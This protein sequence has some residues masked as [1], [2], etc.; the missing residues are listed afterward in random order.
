MADPIAALRDILATNWSKAPKPSIEDIAD[1]DQ[2]DAKRVRLLDTDVIRI[3]ETAHNEAQPELLYDYVNE[4]VNI[5]IDCRTVDS[6]L[7][8]SAMRDEVRRILYAFRKGDGTNFDRIIY[9]TRTDLSD[10]SKKLFRYTLQCEIV[11]FSSLASSA[12]PVVNPATGEVV[13]STTYQTYD[14]DL[15]AIANLTPTDGHVIQGNGSTWVTA[16]LAGDITEVTAGTALSGGGTSGAVTLNVSGLTISEFAANS[17]QI[18]SESFADNDTSVMTSAAIADKIEAYGYTTQVGDITGVTAGTGMAGGGTSGSV[19]LNLDLKDEDN[20]ASNSASHAASQQSIKAYVDSEVT[21]LIDS[22]PGALDTLNELAAAINDDASFASTITTSIGTKLAKASNLSDLANAGTARSNLG[23]GSLATLSSI[24]IS[25]NTNL[26]VSAPITLTGDTIGLADPVALSQLNESNDATD[27]KILLWDESAS[28]WKYMTIDDLQ[29]SIDTSSGNTDTTY[30]ISTA[31]SG[32]D[33]NIVLTAGGSGSGTDTVKIAAGTNVQIAHTTDTITVSSTDTNTTYSAGTGLALSGTTFSMADPADGT[34]IDESTADSAD[35]MPIWDESASSWKYITIDNLQDEIDTGT[36][37]TTEQVQDIV[38]GMFSGNTETRIAATYED[39]DGTIDLVVDDMTANDNTFRTVTAGGNTLGGSET[40]AFTAGSNVTITENGGAVTIASTD[41]NTTYSVGDGGLTQNNFTNALKTK[42]DGIEASSDVTDKANVGSALASLTGD[43]TLYI[44]DTGDDTTVRVRGNFYVDGTTTT[45]NQTQVNVQ[46]AF[47]FEGATADNYET[48]LTITDPTADRTITLPDAAGTVAVAAGTG[49]ALSAAGSMSLSHLGIQS[50]SDPDAD[51]ILIWDDSAGAVAWAAA[52]TNLAIS[53]TNINATDTDTTY[54]AGTGLSLS[55]TTFAL[56]NG[57]I[58]EVHL[59]ATNSPTD[60]YLLSYDDA[61]GGFT[62]IAAG[63]GGEN[64]QNAFSIVA[65]SG[66]DNVAADATT[67]TLTLA[68]GSNVTITTTAGTDTVTIASADTNTQLSTEAVQDIVGAMFGSN[69]ETRIS[70]TYEDGDGTIDLVVDDMT[71][72]DNTWRTVTAGGNTLASNEALDFVAGSNVTITES[73]GDVTFASTDT[74]TTYSAGTGLTLSGTTFSMSDP[75]DGSS[76]DEGTI[77]TDDRMPIWDESASSWKYVTIDN[78]QDEI[79]TGTTLT[80]EE[81]Q[82]IVGGMFTGNTETSITATYQDGDGT[83]DLVVAPGSDQGVVVNTGGALTTLGYIHLALENSANGYPRGIAVGQTSGGN[84][85]PGWLTTTHDNNLLID[86]N[87]GTNSGKIEIFEGS[88]NNIAITPHG[89]GKIV[90][91]GLLWPNADGTAN[92]VLQTNGTGA[93]SWAAQTSDTWRTVTVAGNDSLTPSEA[94][95]FN[96]GSNV[97]ITEQ[98]GSVTIASTD[99]NTQL[100]LLDEDNMAT[101]SATAAASQ[102]S[103]KAYVDAE[104]SGLVDSSPAALNTLNELAAALGDDASFSTTVSTNIGL[105]LAK[106][107]NL[108]DLASASTARSNLGL[109][110]G[111]VLSTAAISDG[112]TGLATADQ[113]H[114]F[115]TGLGYITTDTNTWRTITAGGNTLSTSETLAFTAGSNVTITESGG[116]VTIASTDTNTNTQLSTEQVQDIVGAMFSSNTETRI[117]ATYEDGDGTIDLVVDDMT[118]NDNT[119]RTITAGGNTLAS[120]ETLAFTAGSNVTITESGGAVTIASTDTNTNTTY[121]AGTNISLSGTTFNVDDAFLKNDANDTTSGT[122]TAGGFTTT[123]TWTFDDASS[124]T[125]GITTV[126]TG[127]GFAD[128]DTSLMTAGAIKEKIEAYGFGVGGG[129]ITAVVAGTGLSGGA[130]SGSATVNLSHLGLEA[131]ADPDADSIFFW[132]DS[133]GAAKFL[134]TGSNLTISGTT[135]TATDTNTQLSTEQV[136]DIVGAMFSSNTET[137]IAATYE[138]GDGTIDLV[139][140]DMTADTNTWRTITAGGNTLS[141]SETLAFTA[142]SNVTISENGGAVTIA[143]T[144]TNTT[145]S[146]GDGGLTQNNFTNTLKSKLDAIEAS[147]D[148]TDKTN[149]SAA[150]ALLDDGDTLYIG[151]AGN[152]TTVRIRGNFYV[153]GTTTSVNQTEV[154]VQNAF[155]FEGATADGYETTLTITDPTA[156]RTITLPNSSGTIS[157]SDTQLS[158]EQVQDIVG[159]MFSSNTETRIAATYEDG[160][161]TIDLVVDD[162]TAN[163]N[164]WRTVTAGGNTLSTSETLAFTAGSNVTITESGGA[165]T[166]ASAD[167][168]TQLSTEA[169]QDIVGAMFSGNTETNTAVTYQD[170]DGTIDVVTTLDGAPL[171]TEA[172]QDIV[173]A[174]FSSNTETRIAA[175]YEDG[176]GTIDL[177]VDDMTT[178]TNTFRTV[179]AGGNT[180]STS[181]TLAFTAGTGITIAESGGAVTITNS[182]TD[183]DTWRGITAGGN[184]LASNETLAFTA[185]SNVTITESGGAVTIAS[186]DTNTTYAVMGGGNSYAAGLVVTGSAT[187]NSAFLRKDGEWVV[188]T[189]TDTNTQLSTEQVQDIVGAMFSSNTETRIAA[190]YEDGDGTIDLVVDDMTANT[191]TQNEYA[192]SWVDSSADALLRLT[193]SGAGSG[194]QDIKIVAGSNIT[195]TPSGT[196]LTIAA[197]DTNTTYSVGDGGLTQNNFTNTLKS[198]LDGIEASADVTDKANVSSALALLSG[199]DTLYIGDS[200]DDTTVRVRGNFYVDGTTTTVNQTEVNVQNA[201]VFEGATA[202][203][204]ETTLT[205]TDPTADRTITLPDAAGTVTVAAG[206]GLAL[207]AAGSMSLSHLGIQSLSDPDADRILIWDESAGAVAWATANS[208]LA[209]SGTNINATDTDTNTTYSAGTGLALST[210]TFSVSGA[211]TGITTDYNTARK[212]GRDTDNLIDFTT[213]NQVTF[214]VSANDGVVFKAS[215]EIEATS[216]DISGDVD[217]DGTLEADAITINGSA[218]GSIYSPVAGHASIVTVGTIGTGTWQGTAIAGGY[219]ANDAIDSQHYADGSI[220]NAHIADDAIDSEHYADGSI[221]NVHIA[222]HSLLEP[223]LKA[224]NTPTDN[225]LLSYDSTTTGFTWVEASSGITASSTDTL[226]NKTYGPLSSGY[227]VVGASNDTAAITSNGAHNLHLSTNSNSNSGSIYIAQGANNDIVLT[228]NGTGD[229]VLDGLKWPQADG[230]ANYV[231]K[232]DGSAQLSWV[233]QTADTNTTYSGG[234]GL[235]LSSTTFNVDAAQTQITSIGT[236]GTGVWQGTAIAQ[237]YIAD[238]AINEAK[239]QVSNGPTNGYVLTAQSGNTGG[240]TWAAAASGGASDIDGLS[241]AKKAGTNFTDSLIIGHQTTGTLSSASDNTAVGIGAMDAITSGWS[242]TIVGKDAGTS[243]TSAHNATFFGKDAGKN[244]TTSAYTTMIGAGGGSVNTVTGNYNTSLGYNALRKLS[245][246]HYNLALGHQAL[247]EVNSASYNLGIGYNAGAEI[248]TGT[249]NLAIGHNALDLA[250][251]ESDNI[252]IGYDA[253]GGSVAGGE[254]N[255]VIGNYAGDALTSADNSV[256]IGHNAGSAVTTGAENVMVG[257]QAGMGITD[258]ESNIFIGQSTGYSG[259]SDETGNVGI[260]HLA[261]SSIANAD[262]NVGVGYK[263]GR[264]VK[265]QHNVYLGFESGVD[266]SNTGNKN[267]GIGYQAANNITTGSNN[268]VIG[269]ADVTADASDQLSISSGDGSPVWITGTS[270]GSVNL[271]NS[272]LKI[273]GSVGSDGQVLTSTGSAVAWEDAGGGGASALNGLTDVISNI[274]NFTDSILISPDGAAPPHG[275]LSSATDNVGIGKDAFA[276]L[277]SG[278]YNIAIGSNSLNDLTTGGSNV[279][280]GGWGALEKVTTQSGNVAIGSS[281]GRYITN[282]GNNTFVGTNAGTGNSGG[283]AASSNVGIGQDVMY[284]INGVANN[285]VGIGKYALRD[286][287]TTGDD[288]I[289]IGESAGRNISTA[290]ELIVIGTEAGYT[291]STQSDNIAIGPYAMKLATGGWN[292]AIGN[293]ALEDATGNT[294]MGIGFHAGQQI[295]SGTNNLAIGYQA[296]DGATTESHNIAI[297]VDALGGAVN[298]GEKNIA[299]G[300]YTLDALT[301]S[302]QTVA[303]GHEAGSAI[304]TGSWNTAVGDSS[305]KSMSSGYKN[306]SLGYQSLKA[307]TGNSSV[308]IGAESL[309]G[310]GTGGQN[311]AVGATAGYA[312]TNGTNNIMLGFSAGNNI[313]TGNSNVVIGAADVTAD[314]DDQLSISSGDGSPV[315]IT[316]DSNGNVSLNQLADVVA[317]SSNTTLTQA[318]S[319]SYVYWTAGSCTLPADAAVG[320]QFT[321]FNNTGSSATVALGSGDAMAGSWASNAAVADNDATAYV[322]VNISSS[323][324]QW[325]QVGA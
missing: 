285:N 225:Y 315:W 252:A 17:I 279:A 63:A 171:T 130:T 324:S 214:R 216:L 72:N 229:I 265:G 288:N 9:K 215:G 284:A 31:V 47:V 236:I 292:I 26:A 119:W 125:V 255:V 223:K 205:I 322:C 18:S 230:T 251:T 321:I 87:K 49:L 303:I 45:V 85:F 257:F 233:A 283:V 126:H 14:G 241:D 228:P 99:T 60:N 187:H 180:L 240:L 227:V 78:L 54:S 210:T 11:T 293:S 75:A 50:L 196:D 132:D 213:D 156:D 114:T 220:D 323:E 248:T 182:V 4:H 73:G 103:I 104:V 181:E 150:L 318:Q 287:L 76:I 161:G 281:A 65:V 176:D 144:D 12:D 41:T 52:N 24:D 123:G 142:G 191:N 212:I 325:V 5:T 67:D 222:D 232:T 3:F 127:S 263:S 173:G 46:N 177:V 198:K 245:S 317:V 309:R 40:L 25:T 111:A 262:Y 58:K 305:M 64:N 134:T 133:A 143:S 48:T 277:T 280:I 226:T 291:L 135:I 271:P 208:N 312:M 90:L 121:S 166:I 57:A 7:R 124:G 259:G 320:T 82:D 201:F 53:G 154:N 113:I 79:D 204:Y 164:T 184:S 235:T 308:A 101:N 22:S 267:I 110:T 249:R 193:E 307:Q 38:G 138:D 276:A 71:A 81:V 80:T 256:M 137:R 88:N 27:D 35:R 43:D 165:V 297:G 302:D 246:G 224:T 299:I 44:G 152:D 296:L 261:M 266:S 159:A 102:Q 108:S 149:V 203:N 207:S 74:N 175:T 289:A 273:N 294:N 92:Y 272:I 100:S 2:G 206:T 243:L 109:G 254:Y 170:G 69:T 231:L 199:S 247:M 28:A 66:Q 120:N 157:L 91:D 33:A 311:T 39:G 129:D 158:T 306:T 42:L 172:V 105:K 145:Y 200:G 23:L 202:D 278:D 298:G 195:L 244:V 264:Y 185:G 112:G 68:A 51:K 70:A 160:D 37:L 29:D 106:A 89:T 131:L 186:T 30:A 83:I 139:V 290:S 118:A 95:T 8:L 179:T 55:S 260:G 19:T 183:T 234:T 253:L 211:Q 10:R 169:V 117:A 153:D 189:D 16:A 190:T 146:V 221:D 140:D 98:N 1:L 300:N 36:T 217:V 84:N 192:T 197:T 20:M 115:V 6:R 147:A 56:A 15:T 61:S 250:D 218:I 62:W 238:Q 151:D 239:L 107:S 21:G 269:A 34:T 310:S 122:I 194:T 270:D 301:S 178:D 128:N 174:M 97:S 163:D 237:S 167:T 282:G 295:S 242:N 94:L 162:M 77:A 209:I 319:G 93:L 314:A 168:N 274:T 275:T 13:G 155:V 86:T 268:V 304:T 32:S 59:S 219:I 258:G 141:T 136:Q 313:T 316:G 148:V 286:G 188:P 96:A 116:A